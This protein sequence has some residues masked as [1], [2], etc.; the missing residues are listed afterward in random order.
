MILLGLVLFPARSGAEV[1]TVSDAVHYD[2]A[3]YNAFPVSMGLTGEVTFFSHVS[4][5]LAFGYMP[6][7]YARFISDIIAI[8]ADEEKLIAEILKSTLTFNL[9]L[10]FYP[11][12]HWGLFAGGAYNRIFFTHSVPAVRLLD[13]FAP[14]VSPLR[15]GLTQN[16]LVPIDSTLHNLCL[17]IGWKFRPWRHVLVIPAI[18]YIHH[19]ASENNI[20]L[21]NQIILPEQQAVLNEIEAEMAMYYRKYLYFP[22]INLAIGLEF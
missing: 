14:T 4:L 9:G 21:Q 13:V 22:T 1:D 6:P 12:R 15:L 8:D 7:L 10:N 20:T 18:S 17:T 11:F 19:L 16:T 3:F 2:L 5:N